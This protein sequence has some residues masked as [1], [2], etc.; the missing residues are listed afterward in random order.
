MDSVDADRLDRMIKCVREA[1]TT[2]VLGMFLDGRVPSADVGELADWCAFEHGGILVFPESVL[3][4][5]EWLARRG[6]RVTDTVPSVVVRDRLCWR[7][8]CATNAVPVMI[9]HGIDA[10]PSG[11]GRQIEVFVL[12]QPFRAALPAELPT[13]ERREENET[14]L[15]L[16]VCDP[17]ADRLRQL[18][19]LVVD[20][21]TMRP[22][23]GGYNPGEESGA[24]G[25]SMLYFAAPHRAACG[26]WVH[27]IELFWSGD[28][29]AILD[30]HLAT[31]TQ[32]SVH[33]PAS[34]DSCYLRTQCAAGCCTPA[35]AWPPPNLSTP[36]PSG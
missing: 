26:A 10:T 2:E 11:A 1:D 4:V 3:D 15:A 18:C 27:R 29:R 14:H 31:R 28:H 25:R 17:G 23:G 7:Y 34:R 5:C 8:R 35:A 16:R 21:G 13:R 30:M 19:E 36:P 9:V 24:G 6:F 12:P 22:D 20:L 32:C 33:A